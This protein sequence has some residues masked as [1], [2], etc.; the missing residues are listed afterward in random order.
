MSLRVVG[1]YT[2]YMLG[3]AYLPVEVLTTLDSRPS[4]NTAHR[5]PRDSAHSPERVLLVSYDCSSWLVTLR[6]LH[7]SHPVSVP[8][9]NRECPNI[10][11]SVSFIVLGV[12]STPTNS[13]FNLVGML[14]HAHMPGYVCSPLF[15]AESSVAEGNHLVYTRYIVL[16]MERSPIA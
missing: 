3:P 9:P 6:P 8:S 5:L 15:G 16:Q 2:A 13:H 7:Q 1:P 10:V 14:P 11:M 4:C 12:R